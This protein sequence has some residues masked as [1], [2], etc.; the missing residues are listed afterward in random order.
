[1]AC[2]LFFDEKFRQSVVLFWFGLCDAGILYMRGGLRAARRIA[3]GA[4]DTA[5][6]AADTA[7]GAADTSCH[8]I[9]HQSQ[10]DF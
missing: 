6:G 5:G 4:A 9:R 1:L 10:A 2:T 7:G 3:G 8:L